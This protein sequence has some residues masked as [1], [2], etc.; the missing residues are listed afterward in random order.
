MSQAALTRLTSVTDQLQDQ[1]VTTDPART[2]ETFLYALRDKDFDAAEALLAD[3]VIYQNVGYS[4]VR[5]R[6]RTMK[7]MRGLDRPSVGSM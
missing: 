6:R 3:D 1:L 4:T 2:V 7:L 5:G